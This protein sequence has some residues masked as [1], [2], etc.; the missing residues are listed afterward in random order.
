MT[1]RKQNRNWF[2][3]YFHSRIGMVHF[4]EMWLNPLLP[5]WFFKQH[6]S[7]SL[8]EG[9]LSDAL[10]WGDLVLEG[11][12]MISGVG[13]STTAPIPPCWILPTN[14]ASAYGVRGISRREA[15]GRLGRMAWRHEVP[16]LLISGLALARRNERGRLRMQG[17]RPDKHYYNL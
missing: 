17:D 6:R 11:M 3:A 7:A 13:G 5:H 2:K 9:K 16:V 12:V 14:E 4:L 10:Q 8:K 1:S 15:S